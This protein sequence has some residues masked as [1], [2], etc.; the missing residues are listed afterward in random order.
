LVAGAVLAGCGV[1]RPPELEGDHGLSGA[2]QIVCARTIVEGDVMDVHEAHGKDRLVVTLAVA[3]W[4]KPTH[5]G[6][7]VSLD[8]VD[9]AAEHGRGYAT[10]EHVLMIVPEPRDSSAT[11]LRGEHLKRY[12]D[13]LPRNLRRAKKATCPDWAGEL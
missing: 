4:I 6:S 10:G 11:A 3:D 7:T 12:R 8:V 5:G 13:E 2:E 1:H 9:P